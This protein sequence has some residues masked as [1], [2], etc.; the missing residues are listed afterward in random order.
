MITD[1]RVGDVSMGGGDDELVVNGPD[2]ASVHR[3]AD[4][5]AGDE[6]FDLR[7]TCRTLVVRLDVGTT[8]GSTSGTLTGFEDAVAEAKAAKKKAAARE[9]A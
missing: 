5:G 1:A 9:A 4:G 6:S 7:T 3:S 8:C 2:S